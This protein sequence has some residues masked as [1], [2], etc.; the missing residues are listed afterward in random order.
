MAAHPYPGFR[1]DG[2]RRPLSAPRAA[3]A[4]LLLLLLAA[5]PASAPAQQA[6]T[7]S[8]RAVYA[9]SGPPAEVVTL[10]P[11]QDGSVSIRSRTQTSEKGV[12]QA[13]GDVVI[14]FRDIEIRADV[15]T[16]DSNTRK[17][18]G[19]GHVVFRRKAEQV[20]A[21]RFEFDVERKTGVFTGLRGNLEGYRFSTGK[22]EREAE[23]VYV[24]Q[25]GELTTCVK[26]HPHWRFS[27]SHARVVKDKTATLR[28]SVLRFFGIPVF[29]LPWVKFPVL[30]DGRKSGLT[31]PSAGHSNLK[32]TEVADSLFLVLGRSADLTLTGEYYSQRGFGV[33]TRFRAALSEDSRIDLA[34]YSVQDREDAGGTAFSAD[35]VFRFRNG[36]RGAFTANMTTSMLFRQVWADSFTGL[37]RPDEIL[38]GDVIRTWNTTMVHVLLDRLRLYLPDARHL[39]R[40]LP[41]AYFS[42]TGRQLADAPAWFFMDGRLSILTKESHWT[43][44]GDPQERTF[45]TG[46]PLWRA[47]VHPSLF[48]P[49]QLGDYGRIAI[50]PSVRGTYY[51]DSLRSQRPP[52]ETTVTTARETLFRRMAALEVLLEGPR[53]YRF[54]RL[55]GTVI[56]HVVEM[57]ATWRWQSH[58]DPLDR[59]IRFDY[60]D[61]LANTNEV[62]YF[63]TSRWFGRSGG[64]TREWVSLSLRQK[65]FAD[66]SC[67]GDLRTGQD[68]RISPWLSFSPYASVDG[69]RRFS[70]L[71]A[72]LSFSPTPGFSGEVRAEYDSVRKGMGSWSVASTYARDWLFTSVA[73][74]RLKNYDQAGLRN[75]YIQASFGLGRPGK[76]LSGDFNIAYNHETGAAENIYVRLNYHLDCMGFSAEY[77]RYNLAYRSNDGEFRFSLYL[78]GVG[79]FGPLRKLGR[80]WY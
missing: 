61:A 36:V 56:K 54:W 66:P 59:I 7:A 29:Y 44:P 10:I 48:I 80:R 76:G 20:S 42:L 3:P 78:R 79:E 30:E 26:D 28:G 1:P 11:Y 63:L 62:E 18:A 43:D 35:S 41:E 45:T 57:G 49:I 32:G 17:A 31:I 65:Y 19:E 74:V 73:F 69:P 6:A 47:D 40:T 16:Y 33:G 24:F 75:H 64:S 46:G 14:T 8:P 67:G 37:V 60:L 55:G 51:S 15:V 21:E 5:P 2:G 22:S 9:V 72:M 38:R 39:T 13:E 70:P 4:L 53:L 52:G 77:I 12:F 71:Q 25:D 23:N 27:C 50:Q 68:N 34:T 58:T